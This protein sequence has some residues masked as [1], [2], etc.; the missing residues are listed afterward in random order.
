MD[1]I[2]YD[3]DKAPQQSRNRVDGAKNHGSE[4][5]FERPRWT[6]I[7]PYV[8]KSLWKKVGEQGW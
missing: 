4:D 2:G 6:N 8:V 5:Q 3:I 7:M 1:S